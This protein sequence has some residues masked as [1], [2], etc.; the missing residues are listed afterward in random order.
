MIPAVVSKRQSKYQ[1]LTALAAP[2]KHVGSADFQVHPAY[3]GCI[4]MHG[5][6]LKLTFGVSNWA[7][8]SE[9]SA[10]NFSSWLPVG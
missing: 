10:L 7:L 9:L 6:K 8:E 2:T 4:L 3:L 5:Q 1:D